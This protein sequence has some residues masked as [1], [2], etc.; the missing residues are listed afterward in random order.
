[1]PTFKSYIRIFSEHF[2]VH[3][4]LKNLQQLNL[5]STWKWLNGGGGTYH[6]KISISLVLGGKQEENKK[7]KYEKSTRI[8][9]FSQ[10]PHSVHI[11]VPIHFFKV[12][13]IH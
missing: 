9:V 11:W 1:M 10:G 4:R 8:A 7:K 13:R 2:H 12:T 3:Q 5:Y 6:L